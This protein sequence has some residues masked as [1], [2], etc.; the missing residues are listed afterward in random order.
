[1]RLRATSSVVDRELS[2]YVNGQALG[3]GV[4]GEGVVNILGRVFRDTWTWGQ[5][6]GRYLAAV[7]WLIVSMRG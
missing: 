4:L 6:W 1:V 7:C 3:D 5:V 2:P